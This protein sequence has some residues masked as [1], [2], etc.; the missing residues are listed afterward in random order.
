MCIQNTV[1]DC[2]LFVLL[3]H[4]LYETLVFSQSGDLISFSHQ[5]GGNGKR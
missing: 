2:I 5:I 1:F 3:I 4:V